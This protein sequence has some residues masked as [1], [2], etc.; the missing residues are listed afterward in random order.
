MLDILRPFEA[1]TPGFRQPLH[2]PTISPLPSAFRHTISVVL[3]RGQNQLR[4]NLNANFRIAD[5][6]DPKV[7]LYSLPIRQKRSNCMR[8]TRARGCCRRLGY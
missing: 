8:A 1:E 4:N 2:D 6:T 3:R 5:D 7:I